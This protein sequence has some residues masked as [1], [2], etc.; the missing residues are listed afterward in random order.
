MNTRNTT[1]G[2][3]LATALFLALNLLAGPL[4][5][6]VR[7]DLT[8]QRLYTLSGG[9]RNI[10]GGLEEP[11]TLRFFFAKT[12]ATEAPPLL[13][14]AERVREMLEEYVALSGGQLRL[15]VIDP[16]PYS[17]AEELAVGYGIQGRVANAEG[18]RLYMGI[19]GTN[20]VDDEE[21]LPVLDPRRES[22]LEY[23][24]TEMIDRLENPE[25][26]LVG[27]VSSLPLRGGSQP[28]AQP[29][30]PPQQLPP[31]PILELIE[32]RYEIRDLDPS[33]LTELDG[34]I[35][36]LLLVHPKGLT[37]KGR[38]AIDQFALGGGK[39][40]AFV[41]PFCYLDPARQSTDPMAAL[42]TSSDSGIDSLLLAWGV[43]MTPSRVAG[44]SIGGLTVRD[45]ANQPVQMPL[46]F[47]VTADTINSD[48]I[49]TAPLN[50][51]RFFMP[52]TLSRTE[53]APEGV[54]VE[55]LVTTT[56]DGGG[57]VDT[58]TLMGPLD[59]QIVADS[60]LEN[61]PEATIAVR[62]SGAVRTAFPDG[63]PGAAQA[64]GEEADTEKEDL[65]LTEST[66]PF[67]ALVFADADMLHDSVW[68]QPMQDIFGNVRL[69]PQVDNASLLVSALENMSGSSDLISLRS[70]AEFS[71]PFTRKEALMLDA[72]ERYRAE[73]VELEAKLADTQ[74]RL[75]QLQRD[76]DPSS[77]LIL[78]AEQEEQIQ[79]FRAEQVETRGKLREVK[80]ELRAEIDALGT[81]LKL[82]NIFLIPAILAALTLGARMGRA[83]ARSA[84]SGGAKS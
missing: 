14:Y 13:S 65:H 84:R 71:R 82:I 23:E 1:L 39:V 56:A 9:T 10:L 78:S 64:D 44:D 74:S 79:A 16:E 28:A 22:F 21:V 51:L 55:P 8:E 81:R 46:A 45:R 4:L 41:D 15:E 83:G 61:A 76:K 70:R 25:L 29:G 53:D 59:P 5:R 7:A 77:A 35:D 40:V 19:V 43:Q 20:S 66:A 69:Q 42:S 63:A 52:G 67:N 27:I 75:D 24:L 33:S 73:E 18:D 57:T 49:L 54:T 26:P 12:V 48:D 2:L 34:D 36:L 80:R 68:A 60:F 38:Y 3:L 6:G 58:L 50:K 37:P 31:W 32:R 72:Q 30:Q 62:V 17:E 11:I 47:G